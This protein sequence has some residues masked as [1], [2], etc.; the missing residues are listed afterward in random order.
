MMFS[1]TAGNQPSPPTAASIAAA[2]PGPVVAATNNTLTSDS[3][4]QLLAISDPQQQKQM[5]GE[6]LYHQIYSFRNDLAG[7]I[8]GTM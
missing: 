6:Q 3:F 8:T 4:V 5:I 1:Q 7:R 2:L